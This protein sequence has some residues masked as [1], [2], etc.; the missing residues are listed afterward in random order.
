MRE[1]ENDLSRDLEP[2]W[3]GGEVV[4]EARAVLAAAW[5]AGRLGRSQLDE[6]PIGHAAELAEDGRPPGPRALHLAKG[7]FGRRLPGEEHQLERRTACLARLC[8]R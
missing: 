8:S 2:V 3:A 1:L 6:E 5:R 4:V 7:V